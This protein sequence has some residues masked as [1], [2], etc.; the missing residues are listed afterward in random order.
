MVASLRWRAATVGIVAVA[1]AGC[2][3]GTAPATAPA[4]APSPAATSAV[5][6]A[7]AA[8]DPDGLRPAPLRPPAGVGDEFADA[9]ALAGWRL[10]Q[11]EPI[12]G[13]APRASVAGGMLTIVSAHS[14]WLGTAHGFG[15]ARRTTGDFIAT[16]RVRPTGLRSPVP[17]V[18][19][20]LTGLMVRAPTTDQ[21]EENWVH[22]SAGYVGRPV[23]ERKNTLATHSELVVKDV[24][25]GWVELRIVRSGAALVLLHRNPGRPW[26]F[27]HTYLRP[28]LPPVV[29]LL[30]TAQSGAESDHADL[31][32][33]VDWLRVR[34]GPLPASSRT[35]L[36]EGDRPPPA[37]VLATLTG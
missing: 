32:S 19:W 26:V 35:A 6:P 11:G 36:V 17:T 8:A 27:D 12:D 23:I 7:A 10:G 5:S 20:S 25:A 3:G 14:S 9:S 29:E 4:T 30:L 15:L 1:L 22:L 34:P 16:L 37:A 21:Y 31:V 24:G 18:D 2:S 33:T 13:P 28:D